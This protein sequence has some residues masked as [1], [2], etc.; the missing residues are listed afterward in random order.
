MK[1]TTAEGQKID[2]TTVQNANILTSGR[3]YS[4]MRDDQKY[5]SL[6]M[7]HRIHREYYSRRHDSW[8]YERRQTSWNITVDSQTID[9]DINPACQ[10]LER[11]ERRHTVSECVGY[12]VGEKKT[13]TSR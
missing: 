1:E 7:N 2:D 3:N 12:Y 11:H 13:V 5:Y 10:I 9:G 8:S 4:Q 6:K